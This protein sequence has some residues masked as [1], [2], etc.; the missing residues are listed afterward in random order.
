M[1]LA[2]AR[3]VEVVSV[4]LSRS[5]PTPEATGHPHSQVAPIYAPAEAVSSANFLVAFGFSVRDRAGELEWAADASGK[6]R[7][8]GGLQEAAMSL[9]ELAE[10]AEPSSAQLSQI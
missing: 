6:G 2:C 4:R 9:R 5:K 7:V 1:K 10:N 8:V 3:S